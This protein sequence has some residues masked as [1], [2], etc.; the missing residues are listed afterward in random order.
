MFLRILSYLWL[1]VIT[2]AI[3]CYSGSQLQVIDCP[4]LS[5]IKQ[6]LGFDTLLVGLSKKHNIHFVKCLSYTCRLS[7]IIHPY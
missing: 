2:V 1:P 6:T 5:C 7:E 3:Q 4:A